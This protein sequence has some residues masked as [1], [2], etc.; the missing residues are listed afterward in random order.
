MFSHSL[1]LAVIFLCCFSGKLSGGEP[2]VTIEITPVS[3]IDNSDGIIRIYIPDCQQVYS[4]EI[5]KY[6][7]SGNPIEAEQRNDTTSFTA[8]GLTSGKYFVVIKGNKGFSFTRGVEVS[9]PERLETGKITIVKK[10]S[11][12]DA[13][14][15]I[16]QAVAAG[17][18][19][20]YVYNWNV[21]GE[22][23][24]LPEIS[25][26]GQGTYTCIID[27]ANNCG[28]VK[29]T[30]LFNQYVIPDIVEE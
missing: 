21:E 15:A 18:V 14:D 27:D 11:A 25:H 19:P 12:P 1:Q 5:Y 9:Q 3:C 6:S 29:A 16:L 4:A 24:S 10:L 20:P 30:I 26:V 17:G 2:E 13:H 7:P 28:P 22:S 8:T 23:K